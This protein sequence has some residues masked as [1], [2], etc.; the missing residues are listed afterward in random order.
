MWHAPDPEGKNW[1]RLVGRRRSILRTAIFFLSTE[2]YK[3]LFND[4]AEWPQ[5]YISC[6][7]NRPLADFLIMIYNLLYNLKIS[8]LDFLNQ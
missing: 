8:V 7:Y 2:L 3:K 6:Y 5:G 4:T 1:Y